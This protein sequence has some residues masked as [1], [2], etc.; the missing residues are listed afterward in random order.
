MK[1]VYRS[2]VTVVLLAIF[3]CGLYSIYFVVTTQNALRDQYNK[4]NLPGGLFVLFLGIITCG[5]YFIYWMYKSAI[6][7]NAL[8]DERNIN[9]PDDVA[10]LTIIGVFLTVIAYYAMIQSK[11]NQ[12]VMYDKGNA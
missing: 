9:H 11:I 6:V 5:I 2:P 8:M 3:T 7:V 4:E 1:L 10:L 12:I